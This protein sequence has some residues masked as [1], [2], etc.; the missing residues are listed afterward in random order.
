[1]KHEFKSTAANLFFQQPV[2][3]Y[4]GQTISTSKLH[5]GTLNYSK[6][7]RTVGKHFYEFKRSF[8]WLSIG[9]PQSL[10][11]IKSKIKEIVYAV[12]IVG[13]FE[14][15]KSFKSE[16]FLAKTRSTNWLETLSKTVRALRII[17]LVIT[18]VITFE[19]KQHYLIFWKNFV[20]VFDWWLPKQCRQK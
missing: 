10:N 19:N 14:T 13:I 2:P 11:E 16:F 5:V 1:M 12:V 4:Y 6:K 15:N 8:I 9:L 7:N 18:E 20:G 17:L 3:V